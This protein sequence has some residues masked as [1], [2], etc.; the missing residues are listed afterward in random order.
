VRHGSCEV[1]EERTVGPL[2]G[3]DSIARGIKSTIIGGIAVS[4]FMIVYYLAAGFVA[5]IALAFNLLLILAGLSFLHATLTLP[6]IAGIILTVG[7]AVDANILIFARTREELKSGKTISQAVNDGF[8][9]AWPSTRDG[10]VSTLI[11]CLI[12]IFFG[13]S[14][15]QGFG[16]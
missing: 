13:T 9:R 6:G 14:S 7:M 2:L 3:R 5:V 11:T 16:T 4:A 8:R 1:E 12:L 15:I 10:N